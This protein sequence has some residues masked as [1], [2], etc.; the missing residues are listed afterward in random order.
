MPR[1]PRPI[2]FETGTVPTNDGL[3]LDKD[4]C[5]PPAGPEPPQ[6]NPEQSVRSFKSRM[7]MLLFQ[8]AELLPQRQ[9][10]LESV[11]KLGIS[12]QE[13]MGEGDVDHGFG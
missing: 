9:I 1:E 12:P 2:Q 3:R 7:W 8:N 6:D 10:F 13:L 11:Q 5:L 4:Q